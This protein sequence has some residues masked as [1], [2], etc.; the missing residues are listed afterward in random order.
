MLLSEAKMLTGSLSAVTSAG[1]GRK[2]NRLPGP[3]AVANSK[4]FVI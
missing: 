4:L 2:G 3:S 1:F